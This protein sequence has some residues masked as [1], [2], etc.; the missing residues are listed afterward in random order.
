MK[1]IYYKLTA[2][3]YDDYRVRFAE[4]GAHCGPTL[5]QIQGP[6]SRAHIPAPGTLHA[7]FVE[8]NTQ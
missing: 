5:L 8:G 2:H 4:E 6:H 3:D 7:T 1:T